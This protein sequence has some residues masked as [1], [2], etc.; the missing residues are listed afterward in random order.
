MIER[1]GGKHGHIC[2]NCGCGIQTTAHPRF[3]DDKLTASF[4]EI[5]QRKCKAQLEKSRVRLP[6][7]HEFPQGGQV[8][9]DFVVIDF[10]S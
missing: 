3:K 2:G 9:G 5:F 10:D 7:R 1:D 6:F 8:G 4:G